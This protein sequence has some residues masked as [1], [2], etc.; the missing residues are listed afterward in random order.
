LAQGFAEGLG[1]GFR[2][3]AQYSLA[4]GQLSLQRQRLRLQHLEAWMQNREREFRGEVAEWAQAVQGWRESL[5]QPPLSE[6]DLLNRLHSIRAF[7]WERQ[8]QQSWLK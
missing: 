6:H 3:G 8:Y 1:Q 5:G 2:N 4:Q 7:D